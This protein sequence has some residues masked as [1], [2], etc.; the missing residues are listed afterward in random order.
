[1]STHPRLR[2]VGD[3]TLGVGRVSGGG[4]AGQSF[5]LGR[6]V[7]VVEDDVVTRTSK[8]DPPGA[9]SLIVSTP[10]ALSTDTH[11]SSCSQARRDGRTNCFL[12]RKFSSKKRRPSCSWHRLSRKLCCCQAGY[13]ELEL[14]VANTQPGL[15]CLAHGCVIDAHTKVCCPE[16]GSTR[17]N[18]VN[19]GTRSCGD[20]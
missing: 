14:Q 6:G 18:T 7:P 4:V 20:I 5:G 3:S 15:P 9:F 2:K 16:V 8:S 1:M 11:S 19:R 10:K 12:S 17:F 13:L